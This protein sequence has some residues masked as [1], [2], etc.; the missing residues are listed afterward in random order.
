[1]ATH[2]RMCENQIE[3]EEDVLLLLGALPKGKAWE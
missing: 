2:K 3:E 1:M